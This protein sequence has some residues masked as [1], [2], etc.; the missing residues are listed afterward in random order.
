M[1]NTLLLLL[2]VLGMASCQIREEIIFSEDGSGTYKMGFDMSEFMK[3]GNEQD[4][5]PPEPAIDTLI[6]FASFLDEKKDSIATLSKEEQGRLE[7]LRP[8]QFSM[9]M[10]EEEKQMDMQLSYVFTTLDDISKFADAIKKADIKEL[11][12]MMNPMGDAAAPV[13]S[14]TVQKKDDMSAIFSMAESFTTKFSN[15]GFSRK[16]TE[17]AIAEMSL[18]KDTTLTADDPFSDMIRF[19]Q[20]YRFPY[21]VKSVDNDNAKILSDFK[22]IE[23]E[24]NMYEMNNDPKY[25]NIEVSFEE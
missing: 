4:T 20:V 15:A 3:M 5:L 23:I 25:F 22:G 6:N 17:A 9:K 11:D 2:T 19:K 1:R 21:R 14:D 7:A 24:A 8:L 10:N 16:V 12:Q 18:K 13:A